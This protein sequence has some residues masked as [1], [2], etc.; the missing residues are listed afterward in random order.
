MNA[1][2]PSF[3]PLRLTSS[4]AFWCRVVGVSLML[5]TSTWAQVQDKDWIPGQVIDKIYQSD[6]HDEVRKLLRRA[7]YEQALVIVQKN[8]T[9]NPRDPQMRFWEGYIYEQLGQPK[10]A[11]PIY[12]ALT[13]EHPEL[14]EPHNNLGV[15]LA[16]E[17][18]YGEAR[19]MFEQAL[20]AN[21][22]H[23]LAQENL[24]DVLLQLARQA[25]QR[26]IE[27]DGSQRSAAKKIELLKPAAALSEKKP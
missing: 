18:N 17:G 1:A 11:K 22:R 16:A 27:I 9:L 20:R 19:Q 6:P 26:A 13:Q 2:S 3:S 8:V 21:P 10:L 23:A 15:L 24:G 25:Y 4:F 5:C 7:K 14:A 12:L